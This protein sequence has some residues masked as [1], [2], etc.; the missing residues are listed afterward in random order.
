MNDGLFEIDFVCLTDSL[1]T[2]ISLKPLHFVFLLQVTTS[3]LPNSKNISNSPGYLICSEFKYPQLT[4]M[5]RI[6]MKMPVTVKSLAW[7]LNM[8]RNCQHYYLHLKSG[9]KNTPK[10]STSLMT[11]HFL[12]E[13]KALHV[14]LVMVILYFIEN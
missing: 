1:T 4:T 10:C 3:Q 6:L 14:I 2:N 9:L 12:G 7:R 13:F 11:L 8:D 5:H